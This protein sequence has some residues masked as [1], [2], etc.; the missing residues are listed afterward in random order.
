MD[1]KHMDKKELILREARMLFAE[2]GY[3]GLGLTELLARCGIPKGSFYY[4]FPGG[5]IQLIQEVLETSYRLMES[6]IRR[7]FMTAPS[8][9]AT[10]EAMADSLAHGI[11][12]KGH[13]VSLLLSMISI[14]SVYLD[15]RV[16][17]TCKRIYEDWQALYAQHFVRWGMSEEES[18][19][20]AQA[21]FSLIH[22]SMISSWIKQD[23]SD[24]LLAKRS[25][26]LLIGDH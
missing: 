2:K 4:Y 26:K 6:G 18:V 3:Y 17:A 15:E 24:L 20:K 23:P 11:E 22:C 16:H 7:R 10:F 19:V 1:K 21:V 12:T 9:L 14:E 25:L 8:A 13:Y 5:K